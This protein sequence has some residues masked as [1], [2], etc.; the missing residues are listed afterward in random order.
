M[1]HLMFH[2]NKDS[3]LGVQL[4][5]TETKSFASLARRSQGAV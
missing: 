3:V 5:A 4:I 2:H 1:F